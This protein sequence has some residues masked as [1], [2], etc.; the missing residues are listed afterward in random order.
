[1]IVESLLPA[2]SAALAEGVFESSVE[3]LFDGSRERVLVFRSVG[4][5]SGEWLLGGASSDLQSFLPMGVDVFVCNARSQWQEQDSCP[6]M[7]HP[8]IITSVSYG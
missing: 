6:M 1:M 5:L 4:A 2:L 3:G 8:A 7:L